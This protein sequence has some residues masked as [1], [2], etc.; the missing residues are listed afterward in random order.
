[1]EGILSQVTV[2]V[3]KQ[4]YNIACDNGQETHL[5]RLANYVDHRCQELK[6]AV[7]NIRDDRLLVMVALLLSDE[8]SDAYTELETI[9]SADEGAA[10][11]AD[12][13]EAI[14]LSLDVLA[15]RIERIAET[16]EAA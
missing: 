11:F 13:Q 14:S 3:N 5:A 4:D 16:V 6:A 1:M 9:K 8:L 15:K 12:Q 10:K 2:T 7:G